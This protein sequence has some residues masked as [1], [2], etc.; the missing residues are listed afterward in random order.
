MKKFTRHLFSVA[1][2]CGFF[3]LAVA[4]SDDK[5][6]EKEVA[7]KEAAQPA[8]QVTAKQLYADYDA[9]E[10]AADQKYK[11]KVLI[12]SGTVNDIAKDFTDGIFVIVKGDEMAGDIQCF[13]SKDHT[14]EAA[15][16][17]K[18]QTISIKGNCEGKSML[19]VILRGCTVQ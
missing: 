1:A 10:V 15:K 4:S 16:L 19:N 11:D 14:D 3:V 6:T 13:F 8:V 9:N 2:I 7:E 5:K 17:K 18:E 12:V